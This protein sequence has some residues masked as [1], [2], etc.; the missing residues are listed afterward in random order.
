MDILTSGTE[1]INLD[2]GQTIGVITIQSVISPFSMYTNVTG[3]A[4]IPLSS[5]TSDVSY[6]TTDLS[7]SIAENTISQK[8]PDLPC[9]L[10]GLT[11]ISYSIS[12]YITS[13]APS[14][15][16]IDTTSGVLTIS[17]PEVASDTGFNFYISSTVSGV[18]SSIQK[19][20]KIIVL[21]C[22]ASN[23]QQWISSSNS[24]CG[25]CNSGYGLS[26]G[27]WKVQSSKTAN[28]LSTTIKAITWAIAGMIAVTSLINVSSM[29]SL[30]VTINQQQ[31]FFL[32][33]LT[34]AFIPIDVQTVIEGPDFSLNIYGYFSILKLDIYPSFL[35]K[36]EF[37]LTDSS[38]QSIGM[39]YAGTF[40][41]IDSF[42]AWTFLMILFSISIWI[43][44]W[45]WSKFRQSQRWI[46]LNKT[47]N[48][49]I[50]KLYKITVLGY[51][52]RNMLEMSQFILISSINE[53]YENN[54]AYSYRLISFIFFY[55]DDSNICIYSLISLIS[56]NFL[57]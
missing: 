22:I 36:F 50:E 24:V 47:L 8:S 17:T 19:L 53:V 35:K 42:L 11:S 2:S 55:F 51:F 7:Y 56:Y 34:R 3:I 26:S 10:G 52:I 49:I 21:N 30:W 57:L 33:L 31:L 20:I 18:S 27:V 37:E 4:Y 23:W 9:S 13:N 54:T 25:I 5:S 41:N 32:L 38:L 39:K 45:V 48:W 14:W 12:N 29:A 1:N 15:V 44:K 28:D 43:A 40:A 16:I 6:Q 46:C